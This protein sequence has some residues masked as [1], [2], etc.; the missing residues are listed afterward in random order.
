MA[1]AEQRFVRRKKFKI[2]K[3][4][5]DVSGMRDKK[6]E[7]LWKVTNPAILVS[8]CNAYFTIAL[9]AERNQ[10]I[11]GEKLKPKKERATKTKGEPKRL[12][13]FF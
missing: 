13:L 7:W 2:I 12:S 3:S 4:S 1:N 6:I 11:T 10:G 9:K 5:A 8:T